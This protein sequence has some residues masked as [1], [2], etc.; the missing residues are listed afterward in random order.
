MSG[1]AQFQSAMP[2]LQVRDVKASAAFY[3]D[4]L[5]FRYDRFWGDD[6]EVPAFCMVH[7]GR[8]SLALDRARDGTVPLN[9]Y[10]AAYLYVDDADAL[11]AEFSGKGVDIVEPLADTFY[12]MR[13]FT[14]R[15][16][17]GH[18]LAFAHDLDQSADG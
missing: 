11:F 14:L 8:I 17:D 18:L 4:M 3:R 5:G 9:Q 13:E 16:P 2:V 7:R 1:A 6:P 10:W 15:D 12:R